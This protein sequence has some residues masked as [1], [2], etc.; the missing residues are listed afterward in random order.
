MDR[1]DLLSNGKFAT[2]ASEAEANHSSA[3]DANA[4]RSRLLS[5]TDKLSDS[6]RRLEDSHR[7]ALETEDLGAGILGN[8][9]GQREQ[10]ENTRNRLVDADRGIDRASGTLGRMIR[11]F[12]YLPFRPC[13]GRF[14]LF[15]RASCLTQAEAGPSICCRMYQ[16]RFVT[17]AI[18]AVLII[19]M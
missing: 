13:L 17:G 2:N 19:L 5:T 11:R 16:Q 6:S 3:A 10:I 7:L 14:Y 9:R 4:Q 15:F 12:V 8:L 18:I 1:S